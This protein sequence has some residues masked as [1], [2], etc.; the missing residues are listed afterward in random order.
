MNFQ[1]SDNDSLSELATNLFFSEISFKSSGVT[2]CD[3]CS[4]IPCANV[5][6][7]INDF[8]IRCD[9]V[10]IHQSMSKMKHSRLQKKYER[11]QY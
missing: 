9:P 6:L 7:F 10:L 8:S 3:I 1:E 5:A 2:S 4:A 11:K